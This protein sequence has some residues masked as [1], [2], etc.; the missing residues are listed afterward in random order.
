M[1]KT[2]RSNPLR[3]TA[4]EIERVTQIVEHDPNDRNAALVSTRIRERQLPRVRAA[5]RRSS[6]LTVLENLCKEANAVEFA[7]LFNK[8][9]PRSAK[10]AIRV[11]RRSGK[12]QRE[13]LGRKDVLPLIAS[14]D[15][16]V[17][18]K[19]LPLTRLF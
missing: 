18:N 9:L 4:A 3:W 15:L 13:A 6:R 2:R 7:E 8:I 14:P 17:R 1:G 19:A 5:L 16:E 10:C 11:L 12:A